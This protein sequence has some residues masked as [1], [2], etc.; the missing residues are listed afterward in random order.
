MVL[1]PHSPAVFLT[2]LSMKSTSNS[3][4]EEEE[5]MAKEEDEEGD[6]RHFLGQAVAL[7]V[8]RLR[9]VRDRVKMSK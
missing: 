7:V 6:S 1:V 9:P 5:D 4:E 8:I 3:S 2:A